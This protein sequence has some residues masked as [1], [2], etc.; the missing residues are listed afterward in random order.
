VLT[1]TDEL[2][3]LPPLSGKKF[4]RQ[5]DKAES[6]LLATASHTLIPHQVAGLPTGG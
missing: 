3:T 2:G 4:S 5:L 1:T 6:L